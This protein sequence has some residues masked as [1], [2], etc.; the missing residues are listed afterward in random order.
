M[1]N[2]M[3]LFGLVMMA[4]LLLSTYV[5]G[6]SIKTG[7]TRSEI[8]QILKRLVQYD[9]QGNLVKVNVIRYGTSD[10]SKSKIPFFPFGKYTG[11]FQQ[12]SVIKSVQKLGYFCVKL[13]SCRFQITIEL[14]FF[15]KDDIQDKVHFIFEDISG[16]VRPLLHQRTSIFMG[17]YF[18][19]T[20]LK[21]NGSTNQPSG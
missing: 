2:M 5:N 11:T 4:V 14:F 15:Q 10:K 6:K 18:I 16:Q 21:R 1:A 19:I 13:R 9:Q 20:S 12:R 8:I 3:R 7:E 17:N